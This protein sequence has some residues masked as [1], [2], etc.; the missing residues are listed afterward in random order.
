[1]HVLPPTTRWTPSPPWRPI[2]AALLVTASLIAILSAAAATAPSLSPALRLPAGAPHAFGDPV[3]S[4]DARG[5]ITTIGNVTTTCDPT[6]TNQNWSPAESAAACRGATSG[7]TGLTNFEGGPMVPTNNRLPMEDVDVD[8]DPATFNSSTARLTIPDG[9]TV[10]WAGVHWNAATAVPLN[11]TAAGSDYQAPPADVSERFRVRLTT[12]RSG[13]PVRLDAAPADGITRD[14]WDDTNP[15]GTVSYGGFADVTDLVQRGGSGDYTV[16]DVQSCRGFGGC[17]G[18]WSLTV[19]YADASLPARN[20]NVWHGWQLTTP[21]RDGGTQRFT[22][23]GITPPPQGPVAARIGVVQADGDRGSGPDSLDISS[24]SSPTW[25]PF[26]TIDRPLAPGEGDWFNSTVN[27]FGQRRPD[28]DAAPNLLANL[29]QDIAL[30]EDRGVIG[31]DD[32]SMSFRIQTEGNESLYSQVVHSAVDIYEPEIGITKAVDPPGPVRTGSDV[33]WTLRVEN[34]GIDPVRRA[35]VT[36]PLPEGATYVPGSIRYTAGGPA[37]LLGTKTDAAGDDQADWDS[38]T[39]RL[40]FRV[41]SGADGRDGGT[42]GIAPAP[43]GSHQ[44]TITFRTRIEVAPE[45]AVHNVAHAHGEG[46]ELDDPFGPLVTDAEDP[47]DIATLP[48]PDPTTT[49]T[50][51]PTSTSSTTTT[52][53]TTAPPSTSTSAPRQPTRPAAPPASP[54]PPSPPPAARWGRLPRTGLSFPMLVVVGCTGI[55]AGGMVLAARR[56]RR[57]T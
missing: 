6:Y 50:A 8:G 39:R 15:G 13:G 25:T 28:G 42:M 14:T 43:D 1:M 48:A 35:V 36:D 10:L 55:G 52:S 44:L 32:R 3:F 47:A 9:S 41:G 23:A 17:F 40:T 31:N 11:A 2:A 19:A 49:T 33:T 56:R 30:V 27:A 37:G 54:G 57:V 22:V 29:N 5:D 53:T 45:A 34:T 18:S 16:A 21:S 7:A 46:R 4:A 20:L 26:A 38:D 12:P 24:P 51:P